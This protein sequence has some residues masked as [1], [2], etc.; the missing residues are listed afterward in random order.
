MNR[1]GYKPNILC[2][3]DFDKHINV[4]NEFSVVG[5]FR[6]DKEHQYMF[7][8]CYREQEES[9]PYLHGQIKAK[10]G[11]LIKKGEL[12]IRILNRGQSK[13]LGYAFTGNISMVNNAD[14]ID[15]NTRLYFNPAKVRIPFITGEDFFD[16]II[17]KPYQT[18]QIC[19]DSP[20]LISLKTSELTL[21][22]YR[23]EGM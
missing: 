8:R 17:A 4:K 13:V 5:R 18:I 22:T 11:R 7:H 20:Y 12:S 1:E 15:I 21:L 10:N 19:I 23:M 9:A 6:V 3:E 2:W 14:P 16:E